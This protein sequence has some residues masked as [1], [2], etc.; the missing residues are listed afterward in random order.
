MQI[1]L[2]ISRGFKRLR[3]DMTFFFA[4]VF[5]NLAIS[6]VLGSVFYKLPQTSDSMNNRAILL[7]FVILFN[8]LSSSLEV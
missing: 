2:C 4:T 7:F 1:S 6:I 5:G 3:G 8:A